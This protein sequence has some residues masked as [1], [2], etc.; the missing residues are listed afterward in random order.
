MTEMPDVQAILKQFPWAIVN[1]D[2][3]FNYGLSL[4][5]RSLLGEE[6]LEFGWWLVPL[7]DVSKLKKI[8][9]D[10]L[11][12]DTHGSALLSEKHL[13]EKSG[14]KVTPRRGDTVAHV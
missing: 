9:L 8:G 14:W 10:A 4:A 5:L 11:F 3:E 7:P 1:K 13:G 6:G 12:L 2:G